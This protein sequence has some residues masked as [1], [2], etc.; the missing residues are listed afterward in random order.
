M[1]H[2]VTHVMVNEGMSIVFLKHEVAD[3]HDGHHRESHPI[4]DMTWIECK[5][6]SFG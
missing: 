6:V 1:L 4:E 3:N 2:L 5:L